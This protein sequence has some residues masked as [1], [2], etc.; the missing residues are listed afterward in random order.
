VTATTNAFKRN[1][2]LFLFLIGLIIACALVY[3][4]REPL[5]PFFIGFVIAYLV[6]PAVD[7]VDKRLPF[8]GKGHE[9]QRIIVI[10]VTFVVIL[11][12]IGFIA[13][14]VASSFIGSFST[15]LA[16][17]PTIISNGLNAAGDWMESLLRNLTPEQHKQ[18]AD[19]INNIGTAIG[20]WL[21]SAFM[22]GLQ[23]IP[24]TFT[25]VVGFMTL[26]FF[27]ILFM[28]NVHNLKNGFYSLFSTE[29]AYHM[30]NFFKILDSIFGRYIRAQILLGLV[31][32]AI[33]YIALL[34]IGIELAP[35]LALIAGVFQ[36]VPAIGG[37]LAAIVG[38]IVTLAIA[39]TKFIW[40]LIAYLV[41]NLIGGSVLIAKFQS[42]ATNI[43]TSIVMILIVVG[44]YLGGILGMI[45]ITPVVAILFALYKY[46]REEMQRTKIQIEETPQV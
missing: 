31:M 8:Q 10:L 30:H 5:I 23:F 44:G 46:A 28:A 14:L 7:W 1:K 36:L 43:D 41:I 38:V 45:I 13:F 33:V 16:N 22:T 21:Q 4:L 3:A 9:V 34:V 6:L 29:I 42:S 11:A 20:D 12:L 17:A 32:G 39:P 18:A 37:A 25:F 15:L 35:A 26:P 27:L 2:V 19:L 24:S 40:V